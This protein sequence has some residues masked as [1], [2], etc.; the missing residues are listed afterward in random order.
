MGRIGD[1]KLQRA[2]QKLKTTELFTG[3]SDADR[4]LHK[5][6]LFLA[7]AGLKPVCQVASGHFEA[8]SPAQRTS[9]P[10]NP[11]QVARLLDELGLVYKIK[12]TKHYVD[13]YAAKTPKS[14]TKMLKATDP[15]EVGLLFG[16]PQ[17]AAAAFK[18]HDTDCLTTEEQNQIINELIDDARLHPL[19][20]F[21]LSK[22]HYLNEIEVVKQW[23]RILKKFELV[24]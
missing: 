11:K 2:A 18:N 3:N 24:I 1:K 6:L 7:V 13:V 22:K 9:V 20:C 12:V 21:K 8:V 19:V 16:F 23:I 10:D 5:Q 17:T 14:L 4:L 15:N